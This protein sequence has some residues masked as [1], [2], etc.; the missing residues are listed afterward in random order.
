MGGKMGKK[1]ETVGKVQKKEE[2]EENGVG[3]AG[4]EQE[5]W[6]QLAFILDAA[7]RPTADGHDQAKESPMPPVNA[8]TKCAY[9]DL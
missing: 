4:R 9:I 6:K 7:A 3:L 2:R 1:D 5:E 8:C